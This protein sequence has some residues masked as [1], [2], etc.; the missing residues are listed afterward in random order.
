MPVCLIIG[1][2][3]K[4]LERILVEGPFCEEKKNQRA[5]VWATLEGDSGQ[6]AV[7]T[8]EWLSR[9][10]WIIKEG[11]NL[12][13]CNNAFTQYLMETVDEEHGWIGDGA[14]DYRGMLDKYFF[15][16]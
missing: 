10:L 13:I 15:A 14:F 5:E 3:D 4:N 7:K 12:R 11:A 1:T 9:T 2:N 6:N 16:G 8:P